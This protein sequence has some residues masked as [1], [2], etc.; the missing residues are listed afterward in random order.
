MAE[1][2][3]AIGDQAARGVNAVTESIT[4]VSVITWGLI[5]AAI[6]GVIALIILFFLGIPLTGTTHR[7]V[8]KPVPKDEN[9]TSD[10]DVEPECKE[11]EVSNKFNILWYILVPLITGAIAGFSAYKIGIMIKNPKFGVGIVGANMVRGAFTGG[12]N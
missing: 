10:P 2:V 9:G 1:V 3:G 8:C 6:V 5:P 4:P 7:K 11:V 12:D